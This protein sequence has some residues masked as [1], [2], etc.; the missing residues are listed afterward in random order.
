MR[1]SWETRCAMVQ[2]MLDGASPAQAAARFGASRA[3]AYRLLAA[4]R[5]GGW[6]AL[7]DRPPIAR[8]CPHRLSAAAEAQIVELRARTGWGPKRL[9]ALLGWP[10]STIWRVLQRRGCS[11][12]AAAARPQLVRYEHAAPGDLVH[13]DTKKLGRFWQPGKR[14]LGDGVQRNRQAGW[15]HLHLA[16]DDHSRLAHAV[17]L[18]SDSG[19][20]CQRALRAHLGFFAEHG[21]RVQRLLS[22]NG[23]GY[24]SQ[25]FAAAVAAHGLQH[26]RTRPRRPQTN[27]KAEALVGILLREWAYA[28]VWHSSQHRTRG[29]A[30]YLRWYNTRRPHGS[31]HGQPPISRVSQAQGSYS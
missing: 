24:R 27:G 26:R 11:R 5:G 1:Y 22:D 20:D 29:L 6:E 19:A 4:F 17:I 31:L 28:H 21:I 13:L 16:I 23:S 30:G 10:A 3:T 8:H 15:Q 18:A 9:S 7:R 25:R 2:A 12:R 14:A